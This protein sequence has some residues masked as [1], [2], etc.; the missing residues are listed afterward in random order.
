VGITY[1]GMVL[2]P[3]IFFKLT[4]Q[5]SMFRQFWGKGPD[6]YCY[7]TCRDLRGSDIGKDDP[8]A[9]RGLAHQQ[10][11]PEKKSTFRPKG[12]KWIPL[13]NKKRERDQGGGKRTGEKPECRKQ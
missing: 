10:K 7:D 2:R 4:G 3:E 6:E 5:G 1:G 11:G 8:A 13:N 9:K 12:E